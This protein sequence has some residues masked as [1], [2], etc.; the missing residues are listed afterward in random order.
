MIPAAGFRGQS[1][2][3]LH[4]TKA[5]GFWRTKEFFLHCVQDSLLFRQTFM[6]KH[7]AGV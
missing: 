1:I 2:L 4:P 7:L 5:G 3:N 6:D